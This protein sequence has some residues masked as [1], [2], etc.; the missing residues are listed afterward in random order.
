MNHATYDPRSTALAPLGNVLLHPACWICE[1]FVDCRG[2]C[3]GRRWD[4]PCDVW[5]RAE[6]RQGSTDPETGEE[7]AELVEPPPVSSAVQSKIE[8]GFAGLRRGEN[9]KSKM[10]PQLPAACPPQASEVVAG[11]VLRGAAADA[12][13]APQVPPRLGASIVFPL[14][15]K[16][17]REGA[18]RR[19]YSPAE[20]RLARA[21]GGHARLC[22]PEE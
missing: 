13:E 5:Q 10:L 18:I 11:A 7:L 22:G 8:P 3:Q 15:M 4:Q 1:W 17:E 21:M 2:E 19:E 12:P 9:P 6:N 14:A 20:R 16:A